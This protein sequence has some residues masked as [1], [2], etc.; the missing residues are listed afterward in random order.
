MRVSYQRGYL[1]SVKRKNGGGCWEFMCLMYTY[2][3][4]QEGP[5]KKAPGRI[6]LRQK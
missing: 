5:C 4:Q 1:R 2:G 6:S 3:Q